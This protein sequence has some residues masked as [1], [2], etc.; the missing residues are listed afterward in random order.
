MGRLGEVEE[1]FLKETQELRQIQQQQEQK[2]TDQLQK[3]SDA[4]ENL[5]KAMKD[6]INARLRVVRPFVRQIEKAFDQIDQNF[7]QQVQG[8]LLSSKIDSLY[9][10]DLESLETFI[11]E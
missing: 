4:S 10:K 6:N 3:Q 11:Q 7:S 1:R 5:E 2:F 9:E 8:S